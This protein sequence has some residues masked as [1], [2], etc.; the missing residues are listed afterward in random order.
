MYA[1]PS[2]KAYILYQISQSVMN[3]SIFMGESDVM[4]IYHRS[5]TGCMF[6]LNIQKNNIKYGMRSGK[7][8]VNCKNHLLTRGID[9]NAINAIENVLEIVRAES[10]G[11]PVLIPQKAA[12]VIMK[13][14]ENDAN[15]HGFLY[16]IAPALQELGIECILANDYPQNGNLLDLIIND[17]KRCRFIIAKVDVDNERDL[18]NVYF[19]LGLAKGMGKDVI[20]ICSNNYIRKL[21]SD[22]V[23]LLHITYPEGDYMV[24]RNS[25]INYY[26]HKFHYLDNAMTR[27]SI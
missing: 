18:R 26:T 1:P 20:I 21:P 6:D 9:Q 12:F 22:T 10:F 3:F 11:E 14:T 25:I 16:G 15:E 7:L 2:L 27:N 17:I 13:Y 5:P 8:C 4:N 23:G 19:E 24:L